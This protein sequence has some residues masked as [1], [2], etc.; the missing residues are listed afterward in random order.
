MKIIETDGITYL[1][2]LD[3]CLEW[4]WGTNY[5]SGDLYEAEE[6]FLSGK[7]LIRIV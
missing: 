1:E 2:K 5:A 3:S 6:I 7:S 4:Y